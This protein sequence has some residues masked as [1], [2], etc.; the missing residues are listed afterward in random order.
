[1]S[2]DSVSDKP[3]SKGIREAGIAVGKN[4]G[5]TAA[6]LLAVNGLQELPR[7]FEQYPNGGNVVAVLIVCGMVCMMYRAYLYRPL[8]S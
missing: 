4:A 1:M 7:V 6:V 3:C 5:S 8:R 2:E